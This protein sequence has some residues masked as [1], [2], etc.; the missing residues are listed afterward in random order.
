M[1][2]LDSTAAYL[3]SGTVSLWYQQIKG[4]NPLQQF[5]GSFY[6]ETGVLYFGQ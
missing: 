1:Y 6:A 2:N 4:Q 3:S 5:P